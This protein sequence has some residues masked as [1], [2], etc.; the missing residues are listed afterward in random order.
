[1]SAGGV[2]HETTLQTPLAR[3]KAVCKHAHS[4]AILCRLQCR[5]LQQLL[6]AQMPAVTPL[7]VLVG[8]HASLL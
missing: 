5:P 8:Q 1:M 3:D 4:H 6:Q 2:L 7:Q